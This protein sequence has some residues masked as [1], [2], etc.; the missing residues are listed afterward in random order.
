M[1]NS[2]IS[3]EILTQ[4]LYEEI[5]TQEVVDN[6]DVQNNIIL[7]YKDLEQQIDLYWEFECGGIR[8][9]LILQ[10]KDWKSSALDQAELIKFK[11]MLDSLPGQPR[12]IIITNRG[13]PDGVRKFAADSN[14]LIYEL[15]IHTENSLR[16]V[17]RNIEVNMSILFPD[18][19]DYDLELDTKW[20]KAEKYKSGIS[21]DIIVDLNLNSESIFHDAECNEIFTMNDILKSYIPKNNELSPT[22]IIHRFDHDF[23][24]ETGNPE[25]PELKVKTLKFTISAKKRTGKIV[26]KR[27]N[28]IGFI[29]KNILE[30]RKDLYDNE[31]K[32]TAK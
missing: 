16:D 15:K 25:F 9:T 32:I 30:N 6:I 24:I 27:E 21:K 5:L 11:S 10:V 26:L 8:Y 22:R 2:D 19:R 20:I 3:Y 14:I 17:N 31:G 18:I 1:K 7:K 23:F 28:I 13:Y 4:L 12:G 29:L